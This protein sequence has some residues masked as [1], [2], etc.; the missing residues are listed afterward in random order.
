MSTG[1]TDFRG[2]TLADSERLSSEVRIDVEAPARRPSGF[3][4]LPAEA[5]LFL[6]RQ[7]QRFLSPLLPVVTLGACACRFA[8]SCSHYAAQA[9]QTH[10]AVFGTWLAVRR[11]LKCTPL[12]PGGFDPVPPARRK[13]SCLAAQP[14]QAPL[15]P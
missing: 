1:N 10:G 7:Y 12:H 5:L 13:P 4:Q 3:I 11:L 14:S 15:F 8:P 2:G 6:I 9:V